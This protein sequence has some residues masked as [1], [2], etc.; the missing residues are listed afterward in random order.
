MISDS[1]PDTVELER[2]ISLITGDE[3]AAYFQR[4]ET[5]LPAS[6]FALEHQIFLRSAAIEHEV[7]VGELVDQYFRDPDGR[8]A[9]VEKTKGNASAAYATAVSTCRAQFDSLIPKLGQGRVHFSNRFGFAAFTADSS[10]DYYQ[11]Q[12][13]DVKLFGGASIGALK[14]LC[15]TLIHP[16]TDVYVHN[17]PIELLAHSFYKIAKSGTSSNSPQDAWALVELKRLVDRGASVTDFVRG[18]REALMAHE[19]GHTHRMGER[20]AVISILDRLGIPQSDIPPVGFPSDDWFDAW[21]RVR[22]GQVRAADL[23]F[24]LSDGLANLTVLLAPPADIAVA[25]LRIINLLALKDPSTFHRPRGLGLF[26]K[27]ALRSKDG[28]EWPSEVEQLLQTCLRWP[29]TA[30]VKLI[31][32]EREA[33]AHIVEHFENS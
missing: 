16:L 1:D 17:L 23:L 20:S 14:P 4:A 27:H 2:R 13:H 32:A 8:A 24:L 9:I 12:F 6:P 15:F 19:V 10:R 25:M 11:L 22:E 5:K 28:D 33:R 18:L 29:Q 30:A 3:R 7:D 31:E 21:T 26:L